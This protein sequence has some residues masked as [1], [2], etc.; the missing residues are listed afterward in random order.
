MVAGTRLRGEPGREDPLD[1]PEGPDGVAGDPGHPRW[2]IQPE[3]V[4]G[5]GIRKREERRIDEEEVE[6]GLFEQL[7]LVAAGV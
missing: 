4:A 5:L 6:E 3:R 2:V 7:H 1:G